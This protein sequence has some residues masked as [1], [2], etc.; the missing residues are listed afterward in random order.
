MVTMSKVGV[1][2][3]KVLHAF[4]VLPEPKNYKEV[5]LV[6]YCKEA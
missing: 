4:T 2:K 6:L 1:F 3:P 5:L